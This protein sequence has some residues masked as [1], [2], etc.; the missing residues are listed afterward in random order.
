MDQAVTDWKSYSFRRPNLLA[1]GLYLLISVVLFGLPIAG[2]P[3]TTSVGFTGDVGQMMW[4]LVWWPYAIGRSFNPFITHAVWPIAGYNLTWTA[5]IPAVALALAP[6]TIAFG[7][8][9][10]Y[11]F[12]VLVAPALS[13]WAAFAL[14]RRVTCNVGASALGGFIYGFSPYE[15]FH[16]YGGNLDLVFSFVPPLCVLMVVLLL[17]DRI[18]ARFFAA[19]LLLLLV[20]Q[21]LIFTEVLATMTV[22][23]AAALL[24]AFALLPAERRRLAGAMIPI[25][26]AYVGA[27]IVLSPFLY[28]ALFTG[29]APKDLINS[30]L[31][32][33][34]DLQSFVAP[35]P[36]LLIQTRGVQS[37]AARL[38]IVWEDSG[39]L[40]SATAA[41]A[42][43]YFWRH[44]SNATARILAVLLLLILVAALGPVLHIHGRAIIPLPWAAA[45]AIPLLRQALPIRFTNYAFLVLALVASL[46]LSDSS[47]RLSRAAVI[48]V[49]MVVEFLPNP[50]LM[51]LKQSF[52]T[53]AFFTQRLYRKYLRE[54]ENVLIIG[55]NPALMAWQAQSWMY[56]RMTGGYLGGTPS[57]YM[58]WPVVNTLL[59]SLPVPNPAEQ[60]GTFLKAYQIDAVVVPD[61]STG[62][63]ANLPASL[64][65]RPL[66]VGGVFLYRVPPALED[67]ATPL[68]L[69]Q[70]QATKSWFSLLLCAAHRFVAEGG[71]LAQLTPAAAYDC[72]L[73]PAS[74]WSDTL[75][76]LFAASPHGA[77]NGLWIGP[78]ADGKVA[79][80]LSATAAAAE[81]LVSQ[82]L[83][84]AASVL[85]PYPRRHTEAFTRADDSLHFLLMS[86]PQQKHRC[87]RGDDDGDCPIE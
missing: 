76:Q 18:S 27:A 51:F 2:S 29:A 47:V 8:V 38:G 73:L 55:G 41:V 36:L 25:T 75:E 77:S 78:A 70:Q 39:Y 67:A 19:G 6:L 48:L 49:V 42:L 71:K 74:K 64:G 85:Y 43:V 44:R 10:A 4:F 81:P 34:A 46:W 32:F 59:T 37:I 9:V 53:P 13:A 66:H 15:L 35:G 80:G 1:F 79:V 24:V 28:Y 60:L 86:F 54:G 45:D 31:I 61:D 5:S 52:D 14:C 58:R 84:E 62:A 16:I 72:G 11:N 3:S 56:F 82:Y 87:R 23:G 30:P 7:A 65:I 40:G 26:I 83:R 17:Q 63:E 33:S 57:D 22:F 12:A 68:S 21:C 69:L 50:R 20:L